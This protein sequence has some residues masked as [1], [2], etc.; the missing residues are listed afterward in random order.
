MLPSCCKCTTL[1]VHLTPV[2]PCLVAVLYKYCT[3]LYC[4]VLHRGA[5]PGDQGRGRAAAG[6]LQRVPAPRR[7]AGAGGAGQVSSCWAQ[8][9]GSS[10]STMPGSPP[11]ASSA[12][13]TAGPTGW[14]GASPRPGGCAASSSSGASGDSCPPFT[15]ASA[16][17]RTTAS[18]PSRWRSSGPWS[19][20]TWTPRPAPRSS[21]RTSARW[22]AGCGRG[23]SWW[24]RCCYN[25]ALHC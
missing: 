11:T 12:P 17:P 19:S 13:T 7:R 5:V 1:H 20:S 23:S 21:G 24:G 22:R 16:G 25:T 8:E 18:S 14:T 3:V 15:P 6:S 4:T 10:L 9:G 2:E